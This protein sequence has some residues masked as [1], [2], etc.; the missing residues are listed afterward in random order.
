MKSIV[1]FIA[2]VIAVMPF[3]SHAED[4]MAK[5]ELK[6]AAV[7]F[8]SANCGSCKVLD[9]RMKEALAHIHNEA[10]DVIVFDFTNRAAITQTKAL[11][12]E[13]ALTNVLNE[14]GA[15][16]GFVALVDEKGRIIDEI[17]VGHDVDAIKAKLKA[18]I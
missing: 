18:L 4:T 16:T 17:N 2:L 8:F 12:E 11:A 7:M 3:T 14:Y 10:L 9:P 5:E 1:Y 15:R 6:P 13:K